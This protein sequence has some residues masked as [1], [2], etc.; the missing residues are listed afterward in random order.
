MVIFCSVLAPSL[1][2]VGTCAYIS[3]G[4]CLAGVKEKSWKTQGNVVVSL[5][6]EFQDLNELLDLYE[7]LGE[8]GI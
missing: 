3:V 1:K 4:R 6:N 2:V 7:Q 5:D 8:E